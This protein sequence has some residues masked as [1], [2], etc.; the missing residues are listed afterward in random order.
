VPARAALLVA[1]VLLAACAAFSPVAQRLAPPTIEEQFTPSPCPRSAA[2]RGTTIGAEA[3]A[4]QRI[5]R[6][7]AAIDRE[8]AAIFRLLRDVV[9]KQRFL[10]AEHA[11]L[12]YRKAS[13]T[14]VA[15]VYRGGTAQPVAYAECV[16]TRNREHLR[17]LASFQAFLRRI[18]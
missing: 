12:D 16:V 11:W 8:E 14:S 15:D 3:C 7:D 2:A 13:C 18:R 9:A 6:T 1:P 17:E 10:A 5:L 4:E